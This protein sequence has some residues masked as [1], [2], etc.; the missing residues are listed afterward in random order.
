LQT[1]SLVHLQ[2]H[3]ASQLSSC[4]AIINCCL[5]HPTLLGNPCKFDAVP[6]PAGLLYLLIEFYCGC[7]Y[8]LL[9]GYHYVYCSLSRRCCVGSRLCQADLYE[10]R[11]SWKSGLIR[12]GA[13]NFYR[14]WPRFG[15]PALH[16]LSMFLCQFESSFVC[17][18][19]SDS[20][21][22]QPNPTDN[23]N[24]GRLICTC[25]DSRKDRPG[26]HRLGS[27]YHFQRTFVVRLP[28]NELN[29][30]RAATGP[31]A[32]GSSPGFM[33]YAWARPELIILPLE[34][35][36]SSWGRSRRSFT[37]PLHSCT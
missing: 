15:C 12:Q 29:R 23:T 28:V 36:S 34:S 22:P 13:A 16:F 6:L 30:F 33:P 10:V 19:S 31:G 7:R 21:L 3:G 1:S 27:V 18:N 26:A 9:W 37:R 35:L 11:S 2:C 24:A 25:Q 4:S 17:Q 14:R 20:P 8:L 5:P 32:G